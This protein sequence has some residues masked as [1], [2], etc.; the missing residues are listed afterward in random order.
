MSRPAAFLIALLLVPMTA[1][2]ATVQVADGGSVSVDVLESTAERTLL[3]LTIGSFDRTPVTIE[4]SQHYSVSLPG[5]GRMRIKGHPALPMVA[6]SIAIPG[7]AEMSV[8]VVSAHSVDYGETPVVPSKGVLLR[9]VDPS[10][11]PYTFGDVY[12]TAR[13]YPQR[14]VELGE[15]YIMRDVRGVAVRFTPFHY[16]PATKTLRVYDRVVVAVERSGTSSKNVIKEERMAPLDPEFRRIYEEH[17][18]N[19]TQSPSLRYSPVDESGSMLV[20]AYDSFMTAMEP[21]VEWKNQMG[22]PCEMVGTS[23]TGTSDTDIKSYIQ[24][25]Y[26][27]HDLAYVLLVGDAAQVATPYNAGGSSDP[28]YSLLAGTDNYPDILVGR[29]SAETVAQV[30]TQVLRS[31]EYEKL[32]DASGDWYHVGTGIASDQGPGDDNEYDNEHVDN[33]RTDLLGFTYTAVDQI[34]DPTAS[35]S[36][37]TAAL[38]TGRGIINYTGHGSTTSWG[39]SGFSST[40][41]NALTNDNML[42]FIISVACVNGYFNGTT[43]FGETW[44]RASHGSEPTGAIGAYMSSVNQSWEPPMQAQDEST[45]LLVAGAKRTF[46]GLCYNGSC[47]MM[48]ESGAAGEEMFLTWIIFGD[49]SIRVRT[50]TPTSLSVLH[51]DT[52]DPV[53]GSFDVTVSGVEG[54]LCS[55][56]G[57]DT[58]YGSAVTDASGDATIPVSGAMSQGDT[59]TVTVTSFNAVPY[60][61]TVEVGQ[62]YTPVVSVTPSAFELTLE[63]GASTVQTM[64]IANVG[65]NLSILAYSLEIVD[66]GRSRS[67]DGSTVAVSPS[68]MT[69]GTTADFY[70]SLT[71][72]SPDDEWVNGATLNFPPGVTVN[73]CSDFQISGRALAWDGTTGDGVTVTWSGDWWNIVYPAETATATISLTI[74]GSFSGDADIGYTIQGDGYGSAPHSVSGTVTLEGPSGPSVEVVA[75]NGG[76]IWGVGEVHDIEW[77]GT[78]GYTDVGID[79][80]T[81]GGT[82]WTTVVSSTPNDGVYEWT[83]D[84]DVSDDCLIRVTTDSSPS[85]SDMSDGAFS[86][87]QPVTW[88]AATPVEG[89]VDAGSSETIELTFD[90]TGLI[91]G[92]YLADIVVTSNGGDPVTVPVTLHVSDTGVEG[93]ISSELVLFGNYPNP[94]GPATNIYFSIPEPSRASVSIYDVAGRRVKT[95]RSETMPAGRHELSW[96][97]R[98]NEGERVSSG[99]YF[100]RLEAAGESRNAKLLVIKQ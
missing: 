10:S 33:I 60:F 94:V 81:D 2:A 59:L 65:E 43:C 51:D 54:A 70:F 53:T 98:N 69:P 73:S 48:D 39:S 32:P 38:N 44:L 9:T 84:V 13:S 74:D 35:A 16:S 45:D 1:F 17:F 92:D 27:T 77:T 83:V 64:D 40:N 6:R 34:Y 62:T 11:V 72:A 71:N 28:T 30:E 41:I 12:E 100:Y 93:R 14:L 52:I 79:C 86:V 95:I 76:E 21:F 47:Q 89:D 31:I 50:D 15:P 7:D 96:D 3:E 99:V 78:G 66:A 22:I 57:N 67:V 8:R 5:E 87:Y 56:Y 63:P 68:T 55:L 85:V 75:P 25:Y 58:L 20:I 4:G 61:G 29:F 42:P 88:L 82:T 49:P 36:Q 97:G 18:V 26:N 23:T 37:V 91:E 80:S 19:F 46:G 90:A 24:S